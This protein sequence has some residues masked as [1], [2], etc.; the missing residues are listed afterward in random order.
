MTCHDCKK[1]IDLCDEPVVCYSIDRHKFIH[2]ILSMKEQIPPKMEF[3]C[4]ECSRRRSDG[5]VRGN[6][7]RNH[8]GD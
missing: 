6:E 1:V 2:S 5:T 4:T 8:K 7:E 3:T